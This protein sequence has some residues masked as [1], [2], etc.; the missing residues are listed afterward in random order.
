MDEESKKR[1]IPSA[2]LEKAKQAL[3]QQ[4]IGR[5]E[6]ES[7]ATIED[8]LAVLNNLMDENLKEGT[9]EL[10][11]FL[12]KRKLKIIVEHKIRLVPSQ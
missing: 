1:T 8:A 9:E 12:N 3:S 7:K 2:G 5:E 6:A 10:E 4:N 11:K